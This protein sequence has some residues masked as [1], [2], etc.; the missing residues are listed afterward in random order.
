VAV[1]LLPHRAGV[2]SDG[3]WFEPARDSHPLA[4]MQMHVV[5]PPPRPM[6]LD[7]VR[8]A[9]R[10]RHFSPRTE[11]AYVGW[12]RRF[13]RFHS[14]RHP[15]EMGAPEVT[16]FLSALAVRGRVSASTQNQAL[17]ALVFLYGEVLGISLPGLD[18]VVRARQPVRQPVVLDRSEVRAVLARLT[19]VS[20]LAGMLLYGAGLRLSECLDLRVKDIDFERN[21][22]AVRQGK[23]AKDRM[24][25]LPAAV[26]A[27]LAAHME[28]VR[29]QHARDVANGCG[30]IVLPG[31]IARKYPQAAVDWRWQFVF[32]AGRVCR[33]ARWG[34]PTRF[35]LHET[36]VQRAVT[37][38][39]REAGIAKRASCHTF[40]SVSTWYP[41]FKDCQIS[42]AIA[43]VRRRGV[44]V[45]GRD[46]RPGCGLVPLAVASRCA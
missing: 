41:P 26:R 38:A 23:G 11:K 9:C 27:R 40:R 13:I 45:C 39:V 34:Q 4:V 43:L 17:H 36:A 1:E 29:A 44:G 22:I 18:G 24:V 35:R 7:K 37:D 16:A 25:P 20:W 30:R 12:I 14:R 28:G 8:E 21:V 3:A 5:G 31:A 10:L 42:T 2:R 46:A 33:D 19:G 6:L 32:P 15:R